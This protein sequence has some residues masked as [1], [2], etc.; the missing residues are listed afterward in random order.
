V[1][2][3]QQAGRW[4]IK[5]YA[6]LNNLFDRTYIGSVI[7]GDTNKRYYEAAPGRN[8]VLGASA[9]YQF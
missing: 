3:R 6:R 5:E 7:I 1:Q 9:Q 2:A 8:W 4:R